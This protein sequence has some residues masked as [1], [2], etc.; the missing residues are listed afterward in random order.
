MSRNL[1]FLRTL[2]RIAG[3]VPKVWVFLVAQESNG[4]EHCPEGKW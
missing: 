1:S 4:S 3:K 2:R